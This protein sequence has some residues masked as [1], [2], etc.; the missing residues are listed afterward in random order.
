MS[1]KA[2]LKSV[3]AEMDSFG[4]VEKGAI[5]AIGSCCSHG[6]CESCA[7]ASTEGTRFERKNPF[8]L[9]ERVS[10]DGNRRRKKKDPRTAIHLRHFRFPQKLRV[11]KEDGWQTEILHLFIHRTGGSKWLQKVSVG[12]KYIY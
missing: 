9:R 7:A 12:R 6:A 10:G 1:L 3:I 4:A 2:S 5:A 11:T 8:N